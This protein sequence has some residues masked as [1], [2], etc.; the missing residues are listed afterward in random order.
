[1]ADPNNPTYRVMQVMAKVNAATNHKLVKLDG[2]YSERVQIQAKAFLL[3][4]LGNTCHTCYF[5]AHWF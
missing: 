3:P 5:A 2:K 4:T 1:M